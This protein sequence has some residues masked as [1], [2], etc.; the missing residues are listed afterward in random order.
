MSRQF[1]ECR[2]RANDGRSYAYHNDGE[3]VAVGDFVEVEV[4]G[5]KAFQ[6]IEVIALLD[7]APPFVTKPIKGKAEPPKP[8]EPP[9][10]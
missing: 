8:A 10:I 5:G 4:R 6:R 9:L 7:R 1:I 2:F 3:P